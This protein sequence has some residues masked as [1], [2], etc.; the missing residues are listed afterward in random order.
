[1]TLASMDPNLLQLIT[2]IAAADLAFF[3]AKQGTKR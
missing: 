1:M 2:A 3:G